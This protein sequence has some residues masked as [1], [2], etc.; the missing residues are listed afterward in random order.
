[1]LNKEMSN[2]QIRRINLLI[3]LVNLFIKI[4]FKA[5]LNLVI[6]I[7]LYA[8]KNCKQILN[9]Y[10]KETK[11][12]KILNYIADNQ[13]L[14]FQNILLFALNPSNTILWYI[15]QAYT[16]VSMFTKNY[17]ETMSNFVSLSLGV[18]RLILTGQLLAV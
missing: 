1:M 4:Q 6:F 7:S 13:G 12:Q 10:K 11:T 18:V 17:D 16:I 15:L 9:S 5:I 3:K 14:V 8:Y 2:V